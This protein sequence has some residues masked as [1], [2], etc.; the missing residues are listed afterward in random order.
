[1]PARQPPRRGG[2][3]AGE[4]GQV[5]REGRGPLGREGFERATFE[6]APALRIGGAVQRALRQRGACLPARLQRGGEAPRAEIAPGLLRPL[7]G[8]DHAHQRRAALRQRDDLRRDEARALPPV[9]P[10][11]DGGERAEKERARPG[12]DQ[13]RLRRQQP[14]AEP[15]LPALLGRDRASLPPLRP[16]GEVGPGRPGVEDKRVA[17]LPDRGEGQEVEPCGRAAGPEPGDGMGLVRRRVAHGARLAAGRGGASAARAASG[18]RVCMLS[19][20]HA[21]DRDRHEE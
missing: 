7:A 19:P 21:P 1:M 11:G 18:A 2:E 17:R 12:P 15:V 3:R 5:E 4:F 10:P 16:V 13:P 9:E 8:L 14:P 20:R 6:E